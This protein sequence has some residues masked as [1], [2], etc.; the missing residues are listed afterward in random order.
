MKPPSGPKKTNPNKP[1]SPSLCPGVYPEFIPGNCSPD[2]QQGK[3]YS[4]DFLQGAFCPSPPTP[5]F[6]SN[7]RICPQNKKKTDNLPAL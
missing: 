1:N 4:L 6:S 2:S 5:I 3:N 7:T